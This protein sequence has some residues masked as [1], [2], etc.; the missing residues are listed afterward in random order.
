MNNIIFNL[1][2]YLKLILTFISS[3]KARFITIVFSIV[4]CIIL[5]IVLYFLYK[6]YLDIINLINTNR[7]AYVSKDIAELVAIHPLNSNLF[8]VN[9]DIN[10]LY[11]IWGITHYSDFIYLNRTDLNTLHSILIDNPVVESKFSNIVLQDIIKN[12]TNE[13]IDVT[14]KFLRITCKLSM[15]LVG[16]II[17]I[18]F[19]Y[20]INY[21]NSITDIIHQIY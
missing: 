19:S 12:H 15:P 11:N 3:Y 18:G 16:S 7:L 17:F 2:K 10:K 14:W 13:V 20:C 4:Y 5:I 8:V 6:K 9:P 21:G 1:R